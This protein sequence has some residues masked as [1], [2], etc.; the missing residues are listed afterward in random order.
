MHTLSAQMQSRSA[1][2]EAVGAVLLGI[3]PTGNFY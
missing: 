2:F 1:H 3:E